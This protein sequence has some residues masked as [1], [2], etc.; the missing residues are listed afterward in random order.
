[1][2]DESFDGFQVGK[3]DKSFAKENKKCS[4]QS[5]QS[6]CVRE[7]ERERERVKTFK[8]GLLLYT[9]AAIVAKSLFYHVLGLSIRMVKTQ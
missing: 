8:R 4:K 9:D 1:M 6:E 2:R 3:T 5:R 7:R